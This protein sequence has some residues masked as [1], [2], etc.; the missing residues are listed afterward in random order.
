[1]SMNILSPFA[2][3]AFSVISLTEAINDMTPQYGKL[4]ALGLFNEEG[5]QN[6]TVAV[7]FDPT[8]NQLLPQS[9][10]GGPGAANKTALS[11][12]RSY[13]IP[14]FPV[15]DQIQAG[16]L[17]GRRQP[18]SDAVQTAQWLT[19]KKMNEMRKK[20]EQTDEWMKLGVLKSGQV[21]DGAG[22]LILDIYAD[23]GIAQV[24][25]SFALAT[26]TTD[27]MGKIATAKRSILQALRGDLMTRFIG[28]C[29]DSWYDAF[30]SHP[31]VKVAFQYFQNNNGQNL[32]GDYSSAG[33]DPNAFG[34]AIRGFQFGEVTWINYTGSVVDSTGASQ[35]M[36]DAGS[37]YL[38]P[39]GT[40]VFKTFLAPADYMETVNTEGL[41]FY[42]KQRY[43]DYDKG[44]EI[45][46]QKNPL[47]ICLKP[48]V[49]EK[50]TL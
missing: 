16:D 2:Q 10:W 7:D 22:N 17:Q 6:R 30:V 24:I 31:M 18:G 36:V 3:D 28:I 38:F 13:G 43:T 42:A 41:P 29:S 39:M 44:I 50:L 27:I 37:A 25:L 5:V 9:A 11:R 40:S 34:N 15:N 4:T 32:A 1:M 47:S 33:G 14:H 23:F 49:I 19:A 45:E 21:R 48:L 35:T 8:T 12:T 26:A 20:L 46:C